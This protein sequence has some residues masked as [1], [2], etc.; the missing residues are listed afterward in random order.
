MRNRA[1]QSRAVSVG[2]LNRHRAGIP[3]GDLLDAITGAIPQ[4]KETAPVRGT[5]EAVRALLVNMPGTRWQISEPA[6]PKIVR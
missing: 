6:S 1:G 4:R 5:A 3:L 2:G